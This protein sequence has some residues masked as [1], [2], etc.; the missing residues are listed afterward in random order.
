MA[1]SMGSHRM[2]SSMMLQSD[3]A[4][5]PSSKRAAVLAP[6]RYHST[7]GKPSRCFYPR[8]KATAA[9][10]MVADPVKKEK[11]QIQQLLNRPYT[12]GF[13]TMIESETFPKG[14]DED[15]VRAISAKKNEPDWMLEFRLRAYRRWL[16]MA[17]PVWSDNS[18][19]TI[20]YQD[21][22]YYSEPKEKVKLESIDQV[23]PELLATFERL[24]IPLN[25]QKRLAN[26]AVDAVF[27]SVSIATTFKEE[28][29]EHGVIFMSISE[30]TREHPELVRKYMGSVVP[31]A[32]NYFAALNS[33]V[34]SD[35]SFVFIPKGVRC[36]MEISTYFRINASETG[37]FERTL[38][39]AEDD[40]YVSYLEGCTAPS[41]DKNQLHAAVVEL[42]AGK[43]AEIKYSTVQN[44]YA[45]DADGKG[46]IFQLRHKKRPLRWGQLQ[47]LMDSGGD[48]LR[49]HMEV[50]KCCSQ[51]QQQCWRVLQRSSHQSEA[52]GGYWYQDD[53]RRQKYS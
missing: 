16:T 14:L 2:Q 4:C 20:D 29:K 33:A 44:W 23:D 26:V 45:G 21:I 12:A 35:G 36:P 10:E 27:D 17:E 53:P 22:S 13:R 11:A 41:Y 51:G 47:D 43:G 39:V 50:S 9:E 42:Y 25:E 15:V 28:L 32:D 38:I 1:A 34:F 18:Y 46:G 40:A 52:A 3:P 6:Q 8:I 31:V 49:Y 37:Q 19:P 5:G 7:S 30:A 24:G 48:W